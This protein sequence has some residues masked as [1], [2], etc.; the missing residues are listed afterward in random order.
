MYIG[1]RTQIEE[2]VKR[3]DIYFEKTFQSVNFE[4]KTKHRKTEYDEIHKLF[5]KVFRTVEREISQFMGQCC[6]KEPQK[7]KRNC[8][9]NFFPY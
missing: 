9:I 3:G 1:G 5:L 6:R 7:R 2:T 4:F 8:E